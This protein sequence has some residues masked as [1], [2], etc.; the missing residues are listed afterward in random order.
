MLLNQLASGLKQHLLEVAVVVG[1][2]PAPAAISGIHVKGFYMKPRR[3][4]KPGD[5]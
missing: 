4:A 2:G 3:T 1:A 5:K